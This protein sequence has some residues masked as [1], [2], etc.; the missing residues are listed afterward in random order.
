MLYLIVFSFL[1]LLPLAAA[2]AICPICTVAVCAGV[3][4]SRWLGVDDT[5]T[6]LWV[7]GLAVSVSLWT[8]DW[9][10]RKNIKFFGRQPLVFALYYFMIIW[11]LYQFNFIGHTV[12]KIWG[13]DRLMLGITAG[14][15]GF[16]IGALVDLYLRSKNQG[17]V[18]FPFQKVVMPL[19][20]L[21]LLSLTFYFICTYKLLQ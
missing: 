18:Y 3:G 15:V 4:L 2:R 21:A 11:P 7:G 10:S 17:K 9:L 8:I 12:N 5:I 13:I 14:T 1:L 19:S 6:G 16:V 20:M